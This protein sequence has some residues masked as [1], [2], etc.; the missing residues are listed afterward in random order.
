VSL[1]EALVAFA[2]MAFGMLGLVGMQA[3]LRFNSDV[4]RQRSEAVRI[5]EQAIEQWRAFSVL[6]TDNTA[7]RF[8]YQDIVTPA[9]GPQS[10]TGVNYNASY[11][12]TRTMFPEATLSSAAIAAGAMTPQRKGVVVDVAWT[13]R[14]GQNQN[15]RLVSDVFGAAPELAGTLAVTNTG[16]AAQRPL[17]RTRTIP[18]SATDFGNGTSGFVPP[19]QISGTPI[20]WRFDNVTGVITLCTTTVTNTTDLT[21]ASLLTCGTNQALLLDGFIRF[22][23]GSVQPDAVALTNPLGPVVGIGAVQLV[24][25]SPTT[26]PVACYLQADGSGTYQAYFC[27]VPITSSQPNWSGALLFSS[28]PVS[29]ALADNGSSNYK[30]CRYF[31][32]GTYATISTAKTNQNYVVIKAGAGSGA[33]FTCPTVGTPQVWPHQPTS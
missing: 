27:A 24:P 20:A 21:S 1:I 19:G 23:L 12:V 7:Q 4:S 18:V 5:A 14:T 3:T 8:A 10:V 6:D 2:V 26:T 32:P 28:P 33:G 22:A 15:V 16:S 13:D 30:V 17:G 11:L 9:G 29:S 25:T 31:N